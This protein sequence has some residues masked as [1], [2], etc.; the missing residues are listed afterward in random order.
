MTADTLQVI[1][2]VVV[3][4]TVTFLILWGR[5]LIKGSV[6]RER[7]SDEKEDAYI[8]E[9]NNRVL[10]L[11]REMKELRA[12]LKNRDAEYIELY[13]KWTTL[14]AQHEVLQADY[15]QTVKELHDTQKELSSLKEDIKNKASLAAS[16]MQK[17]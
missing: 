14:K 8:K 2:S 12:E 10:T 13:K 16:E 1:L 17:L 7:R 3:G 15:D 11:E 6:N 9:L 4:P 5:A